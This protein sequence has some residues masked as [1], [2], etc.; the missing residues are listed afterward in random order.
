LLLLVQSAFH[1]IYHNRDFWGNIP[2]SIAKNVNITD[3]FS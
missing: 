1:K 2:G 3:T